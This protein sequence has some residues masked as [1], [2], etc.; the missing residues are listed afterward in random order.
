MPMLFNNPAIMGS[1]V[2]NQMAN[3]QTRR[4]IMNNSYNT[5]RSY[6]GPYGP[7]GSTENFDRSNNTPVLDD[8]GE[9][10]EYDKF[11]EYEE[12]PRKIVRKYI[13]LFPYILLVIVIYRKKQLLVDFP[14]LEKELLRT[15]SE[16]KS[17]KLNKK[18]LLKFGIDPSKVRSWLFMVIRGKSVGD[19]IGIRANTKILYRYSV[20]HIY[21][22]L[23]DSIT[24]DKITNQFNIS[25]CECY[26][27]CIKEVYD[28][29]VRQY[30]NGA[31]YTGYLVTEEGR[32]ITTEIL[33]SPGK[34]YEVPTMTTPYRSGFLIFKYREELIKEINRTYE[35]RLFKVK[36]QYPDPSIEEKDFCS[37][38]KVSII[39][40]LNPKEFIN[41]FYLCKLEVTE[42][43]VNGLEV[44]DSYS[45][46]ENEGVFK[47]IINLI[48][49]IL[50][51]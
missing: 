14:K 7:I 8:Y 38:R 30:L 18:S 1:Y 27:H 41:N 46:V 6:G 51:N 37:F 50:T 42:N 12:V 2:L 20:R 5:S 24:K 19:I 32:D 36:A 25:S 48:R 9:I 49:R 29:I 4:M 26:E 15:I 39:E 47:K 33:V 44:T 28:Y 35:R 11:E 13:E 40:E 22:E 10:V 17:G 34:T 21:I 43:P 16:L 23:I 45:E 3:N 31:V